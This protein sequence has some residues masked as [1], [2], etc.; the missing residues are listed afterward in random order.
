MKI[1]ALKLKL[2]FSTEDFVDRLLQDQYKDANGRG[3]IVDQA[4]KAGIRGRHIV[5]R[6]ITDI[7]EGPFGETF[8][9]ALVVFDKVQFSIN[10]KFPDVLEIIGSPRRTSA[11]ISDLR[12][13]GGLGTIVEDLRLDIMAVVKNLE[14]SGGVCSILSSRISDINV[15]NVATCSVDMQG[16]EDIRAAIEIFLSGKRYRV[17]QMTF[18]FD[19]N[20]FKGLIAI[21]GNGSIK[22]SGD[23]DYI[24]DSIRE[25]IYFRNSVSA[26]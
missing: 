11:F 12:R 10:R 6:D 8:E 20:G 1:K 26:K 4:S 13:A 3:F 16:S 5:K 7:V 22:V 15:I 2:P 18:S 24:L 19:I 21:T 17:Q 9:R 25:S 14:S 23:S